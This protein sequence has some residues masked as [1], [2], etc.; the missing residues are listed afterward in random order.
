MKKYYLCGVSFIHELGE[1]N[2][3]S[4]MFESLEEFKEKRSC[5]TNCG[6]VEIEVE[7]GKPPEEYSSHKWIVEES[8]WWD[9]ID[10]KNVS[11]AEVP[12]TDMTAD[13]IRREE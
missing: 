7:Y 12:G 3:D 8:K 10:M 9:T 4:F 2:M 5:W 1:T 6:I 13:E 11:R